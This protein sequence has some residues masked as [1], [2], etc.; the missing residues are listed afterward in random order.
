MDTTQ[1]KEATKVDFDH[2]LRILGFN[3]DAG[4]VLA[5]DN[6]SDITHLLSTKGGY[7]S[8]HDQCTERHLYHHKCGAD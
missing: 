4:A 8:Y 3:Y 6:I 2:L 5:E 1:P 7:L